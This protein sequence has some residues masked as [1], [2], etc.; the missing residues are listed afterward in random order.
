MNRAFL[1]RL[2]LTLVLLW[3]PAATL[4]ADYATV[5][6][7]HRFGDGR[8]PSTNTTLTEFRAHLETLRRGN[9]AVLPLHDIVERLRD[10]QPLPDR[11]VALTIDD[12]FSSFLSGA[13]PLLSEFGYPATL[14]VNTGAVGGPDYLSWAEL[15]QVAAA[16]IDI[17]NHSAAH[18]YLLNRMRGETAVQWRS[19]VKAEIEQAQDDLRKH[20]GVD[21]QLF[22]YP[23]GEFSRELIEVV[24]EL[25]FV[26]AVG[27]QSGP[28]GRGQELFALPR[29]P[30]GGS[31]GTPNEFRDRLRFKPLPLKVLA[32]ADAPLA[33]ENPPEW[34]V[35]VDPLIEQRTLRC[36]SG[37]QST[38]VRL[39]DAQRNEYV[40][41]ALS[42]LTG[43]RGKY[44]LTGTDRSGQWYWYSQLWVRPR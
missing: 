32:P 18:G 23:Y 4:A 30:A 24:R 33:G 42:A 21:A 40:V 26:G 28:L 25:G 27:Q 36:Y 39:V 9:Y 2:L 31:Y 12:A 5:F 43:R 38:D 37:G 34:R 35:Q 41:R 29:F 14:F 10:G 17:G 7:Y 6:I 19:R 1:R 15:H 20:L 3:L 16:G 44:T 22:A 11:C 13:M 8:Y